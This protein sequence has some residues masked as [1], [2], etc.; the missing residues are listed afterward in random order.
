VTTS[1]TFLALALCLALAAGLSA[2]VKPDRAV[3]AFLLAS[4]QADRWELV[5]EPV[6][7]Q[8]VA[9]T[10]RGCEYLTYNAD[11]DASRQQEQFAEAL[12]AGADV[13]VLN[14]VDSDAGERM[15]LE[16]G[17]VP[18]VAYDRYVAGADW[19]VSVDPGEIGRLM[20]RAVVDAAGRRGE[21]VVV[22]G[23]AGDTNASAIRRA[24]GGVLDDAGVR[25]VDEL[26]PSS[27]SE[28]EAREFV[29][30]LG[31]RRV[32][33]LDAVVAGN[34]TQAGGVAEAFQELGL[35]RRTPYLTGQDAQLD[36]V[37]RLVSGEQ[38]M[39]VYKPLP[40]LARRAADLAVDLMSGTV[41][42]GAADYE[43][44]PSFL[45]APVPVT[46]ATI[47][48]TVVH[49][50]VYGLDD[51]CPPELVRRCEDLALL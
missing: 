4:T 34:D 2:C 12:D 22:N 16:A 8:Q 50:G 44:V 37:H 23:G 48:R 11:Q 31:R 1:R 45:L 21:V 39:T 26:A 30:G 5:D 42:T 28:E 7:R 32:R 49:D 10:C 35:G 3:V 20:G 9:E 38:G 36:A 41:V 15:V 13:V 24:L 47:A 43:G 51:V 6:F 29:Q 25:V 33:S 18:V 40:A 14:A 46:G 27:W 19:F 17:D